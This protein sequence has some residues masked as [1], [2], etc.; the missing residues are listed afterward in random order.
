[1]GILDDL[2]DNAP[3]AGEPSALDRA[4]TQAPVA[5]QTIGDYARKL[6]RG[7]T[8]AFQ[9]A[10]AQIAS[11]LGAPRTAVEESQR[12]E[13]TITERLSPAGRF[14][15][16]APL[17][18]EEGGLGPAPVQTVLSAAVESAPS[19]VQAFVAGKPIFDVLG[20]ARVAERVAGAAQRV[21][22]G[23]RTAGVVG[24]AAEAVPFAAVEGV[25]AGVM[26][27]ADMGKR[28]RD[29]S[30][31]KLRASPA[32]DEAY[33]ATDP[34]ASPE[35]RLA[36][37]REAIAQR[38]ERQ[39]LAMT[40]ASTGTIGM[41]TGA[42]VI[43]QF[44]RRLAGRQGAEAA[45]DT[46][47]KATIK[48]A[49]AEAAQETPQSGA[50]QLIANLITRGLIDPNQPL[51][52][53]VLNAAITGGAAGGLLGGLGG[54][55]G[56][57]A[58]RAP[59]REREPTLDEIIDSAPPAG[60]TQGPIPGTTSAF[61]ET[62]TPP[63]D[64]AAGP[65][66]AGVAAGQESGAIATNA[67]GGPLD[68][69]P[70]PG[71]DEAVLAQR[72]AQQ[73][74]QA[75]AQQAQREEKA[76]DDESE[77]LSK[78][79]ERITGALNRA[80]TGLEQERESGNP[81][82]IEYRQALVDLQRDRLAS[83]NERLNRLSR[84]ASGTETLDDA[85][86]G[87]RPGAARPGT[88]MAAAVLGGQSD[89]A[90][91]S[92]AP[93][94]PAPAGSGGAGVPAPESSSGARDGTGDRTHQPDDAGRAGAVG[95]LFVSFGGKLYPVD[96]LEDAAAKWSQFR[97]TS[98]A[99]VSKI[100]NGVSVVDAAG[101][102]VGRVSYNG[103]IW[104]EGAGLAT[105]AV[106]PADGGGARP[107]VLQNRDRSSAA[108]VAQMA[109]IAGNP[110]PKRLS[111]SR[112]FGTGAPVVFANADAAA[113][114]ET[115]LGAADE[116]VDAS[117]RT[118]PVQY[119][120]VEAAEVVASNRADGAPNDLYA[121]AETPGLIRAV[122][123]NGRMAGLQEAF[124]RGTAAGYV[125]GI[126]ADAR[127][128]GVDPDVIRGMQNPVLVR[129]MR[130]ADVTPD[131]GDRSNVSGI[132][133]LNPVEQARTDMAR[134][135]LDGLEFGEDGAPTVESVRRFVQAMPAP[136]QSSLMMAGGAPGK[137]AVDRLMAATFA[138]AYGATDLIELYA[139]ATDPEARNVISALA[140]AAGPMARL[141]GAGDLDIRPAV[142]EAVRAA[143]NASRRGVSLA[144][145]SQ[146]RDFDVT[147]EAWRVV[148]HF[149]ANA[150]SAKRMAEG[151]RN[152]ADAAYAESQKG[153]V[154]MF[155]AVPKRTGG[156]VINEVFDGQQREGDAGADAN[157]GRAGLDEEGA[158]GPGGRQDERTPANDPGQPQDADRPADG[159]AGDFDLVAPTRE[160]ILRQQEAAE[161]AAQG[162]QTEDEARAR[163]DAEREAADQVGFLQPP[164]SGAEQR[165]TSG[166]M[167]GGPT[168]DDVLA[169]RERERR[170]APEAGGMFAAPVDEAAAQ[171]E[172]SAKR[173]RPKGHIEFASPVV[174]P[175][176]AKLTD[177][178]W[179]W[180]YEESVDERG[181]ER[182]RRISDWDKAEE[183]QQTGR[184]IVHQF[185][186]EMPDGTGQVVSA[187]TALQLLGFT[188]IQG[189]SQFK[190]VESAAKTLARTQMVLT[191]A[192]QESAR[193]K[194]DW[195][196][197]QKM[198]PP[199]PESD[200]QRP[201]PGGRGLWWSMGDASIRQITDGPL[202]QST[203]EGLVSQWRDNRM[204]EKGWK[205]SDGQRLA[206]TVS[207]LKK[208]IKVAEKRIQAI[209][210]AASTE[211]DIPAFETY[212]DA[213]DWVDKQAE[214]F[215]S[216]KQ[217]E[218]TNLYRAAYPQIKA[219]Y[220]RT[221]ARSAAAQMQTMTDA[222]IKVGDLVQFTVPGFM[223]AAGRTY[224][225]T[226][227][228][229]GGHPV[230]KID[231]R[232]EFASRGGRT[233][234]RT[235]VAWDSR[236]TKAAAQAERSD[237]RV[238]RDS[239]LA[240]GT[241]IY[242][243]QG[244]P[245]RVHYQRNDLVVAHPIIDG[246]PR[247]SAD[248]SVRFWVNPDRPA[249]GENDRTDPIYTA[250]QGTLVARANAA[251]KGKKDAAAIARDI[252]KERPFDDAMQVRAAAR[253][254]IREQLGQKALDDMS[255]GSMM[256]SDELTQAVHDG[257]Y[258]GIAAIGRSMP[259]P[260]T[261]S[262]I[263][264]ELSDRAFYG[265]SHSPERR[266]QSARREYVIRMV[267][268]WTEAKQ[269][270][271]DDPQALARITDEFEKLR[272]GYL[273]RYLAYLGAHSNVQSSMIAGP[274]RFPVERNRKRSEAADKRAAD[275]TEFLRKGIERLKKSARAP[276]DQSPASEVERIRA[277]LAERERAQKQMKAVNAALRKGD[278]A[279]LRDLGLTDERIAQLKKPDFAGRTGFPSY[280]LTNN[281]AE[282]R[283]LRQ[284]LEQAEQRAGAAAEGPT[285]RIVGGV[286]IEE[287]AQANRIRLYFDGKPDEATRT[288][289]KASGF[290][291]A[292]SVGAWQRQLT[293]SARAAAKRVLGGDAVQEPPG[294]RYS[295]HEPQ[296]P[297]QQ[298]EL[299]LAEGGG[300]SSGRPGLP[301]PDNRARRSAVQR[302]E[303]TPEV[304][305]ETTPDPAGVY[306]ARTELV[307][308][309]HRTIH[310]DRVTNPQ[311]AAVALAS[312]ADY[313]V[314][315]FHG[316]VTDKAGKPL[317]LVGMFRG[318][319]AETRVYAETIYAEAF[320]VKGAANIWFTH[321]HPS[322]KAEF[323]A[324][325]RTMFTVLRNALQGTGIKP[326]GFFAQTHS[327][328]TNSPGAWVF[329][330]NGHDT[331]HGQA[332]PADIKA[333]SQAAVPVVERVIVEQEPRAAITNPAVAKDAAR[334]M[335][336]TLGT[337]APF[338]MLMSAQNEPIGAYP[339]K[340]GELAILR[341]G[342][343]AA[344]LFRA[345]STA[346]ARASILVDAQHAL[347]DAELDNV[348]GALSV[349]TGV[350]PLDALIGKNL[351][352]RMETGGWSPPLGSF[353]S[354]REK[355][356][357]GMNAKQVESVANR[358]RA[359]WA[360]GPEVVVLGSFSDA[361]AAVREAEARSKGATG[362]PEGFFHD[363]KVYLVAD[364]LATPADVAR[365]LFHEALGH[366]GLRGL[367]GNA[368]NGVLDKVIE[369]RRAEVIA[370]M[371]EYGLPNTL[372]GRRTAAEEVLAGLAQTQPKLNLVRAAIAAI[373]SWLR[374]VLPNLRV[375][376]DELVRD[377]IVPARE[378]VESGAAAN[379]EGSAASRAPG[380][381]WTSA[382]EQSIAA[383][384]ARAQPARQWLAQINA[385]TTKGVKADEIEWS[386]IREWLELQD[387]RVTKEA[388]L[389]YLSENGVRVE[390][391]LLG[392]PETSDALLEREARRLMREDGIENPTDEQVAEFIEEHGYD[393]DN[394]RDWQ[395]LG[396]TKFGNYRVPGSAENYREL[397]LTLPPA[398]EPRFQ[399]VVK[400][401]GDLSFRFNGADYATE[402]EARAAER[403]ARASE[404]RTPHWNQPNVLAHI[405]FDER[406]DADGKRVLFVNE[407]QSDWG[408][409]GRKH[410]F[411]TADRLID[412]HDYDWW[413][414]EADRLMSAKPFDRDAAMRAAENRDALAGKPDEVARGPFV[415]KTDAWVAL[416]L[417]RVIRYAVDNG[418]DRVALVNGEQ[419]ADM[420]N[421]AS[422]ID[423]LGWRANGDGTVRITGGYSRDG[424]VSNRTFGD[425]PVEKL[426]EVV[427]KDLAEKIRTAI[428]G[429]AEANKGDVALLAR[430]GIKHRP[431]VA[432][433]AFETPEG[434]LT[435][436]EFADN[437][438]KAGPDVVAAAKRIEAASE[439]NGGTFSGLD[440]RVGGEGMEKFYP[441]S[442]L[443]PVGTDKNGKPI[444]PIVQLVA[445]KVLKQIGGPAL[446]TV[447]MPV[448]GG[449]GRTMEVDRGPSFGGRQTIRIADELPMAQPGFDI[450]P[451]MREQ[452]RAGVPMFSRAGSMGQRA[453]DVL[454]SVTVGDVV[455]R[456]GNR[457]TDL[458][459]IGLQALG[460]RQLT[461]VYRGLL[462][463]LD[464]YG[465][466][467]QQ[468]DAEKNETAA[469][470]DDLARR[471]GRLTDERAVADVMHDATLAGW[472]PDTSNMP[473]DLLTPE[474]RNLADRFNALT[475]QAKEVYREARDLYARHYAAVKAAVRARIERAIPDHARRAE[476]L[477]RM[478]A[479]MFG[480]L[481]GV[482]FPLARFGEYVVV[483]KNE[484]GQ[485]E[486]VSRAET[487]TEAEA[488]R[489]QLLRRFPASRGFTVGKILKSREFN[490]V[491]DGVGRGFLK[492]LY[493]LLD[494]EGVG[495]QLQDSINQLYLSSLPDLS[496]AK[497]GLHRKG[498]P[499]FSQDA[500]RAFA[501][502]VFHGARY[503][504]KL[505]H[506]DRLADQLMAMQEHVDERQTD[507]SYDSIAG[508]QVVDE[509]VKRHESYMNPNT[510][511]TATTAT[512]LGFVFY[513]GLSPASAAVN[514]SQTPLVAYPLMG[515]KWGFK[516]AGALLLAASRE[517]A[518][519]G[520][521]LSKTLKDDELAAFH[522]AAADGTIDVTQAHDL[523]GIAQGEDAKVVW[524]LRPVMRAASFLFHHAERF[525]R[526]A[527]FLASYR[528]AKQASPGI[529]K[530]EAYRQ[531]K[532][533]TYDAHFDYSS[534]SRPRI[535][536]GNVARVVLLF[537]QFA[538]NMIWTL[539]RTGYMAAK[540]DKQALRAFSALVTS[541]ALAAGVLGLPLVGVLLEAAS[542]LGSSDDEPWDA[543]GALRNYMAEAIGKTP[544]AV[545]AHGLSRLTPWDISGRVGL[546][547]LIF[548]DV[549]EGL[550]GESWAHAAAASA[551]GPVLNMALIGPA[552]GL[553]L[554]ADGHWMRGLEAM[555]PAV[556]R[557]GLKSVRYATEGA[558]TRDGKTI[559][560][561][562]GVAEWLGQAAGFSPSRVRDAG[563]ARE[564]VFGLD[565]RINA[566]R[567]SLIRDYG[568]AVMAKDHGAMGRQRE[569]VLRFNAANPDRPITG[570]TIVQS[571]RMRTMRA[572]EAEKGIYLP[573][574]RRGLVEQ[575][576]FADVE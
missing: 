251:L 527:T 557:S 143:V 353:F 57:L 206:D 130:S 8:S 519:A 1:M 485:A 565:R 320:R 403:A 262:Q 359:T 90:R 201:T 453:T 315:H 447:Q 234:S 531:A 87:Q 568:D 158:G 462:P 442:D 553:S 456:F 136:E 365:V 392:V 303:A 370:K 474:M 260:V 380:T 126:A 151:L 422:Q 168:A 322:G 430:H 204:V 573:R 292:P 277:N 94:L 398:G 278:D 576:R 255:P 29:L 386:G 333:S 171:A 253:E 79:A 352:S 530:D 440:L 160:D 295:V 426:P 2:V 229:R 123:G 222:G 93:A 28:V 458:R 148:E 175:S 16:S 443:G 78:A 441:R 450:T 55:A 95:G 564:I 479:E 406:T 397:L 281:N 74:E 507:E 177:Y 256:T 566:R 196:A 372:D 459:G 125:E 416:A 60:E 444:Y 86:L 258:E 340:P 465:D 284:R 181:E 445:Q 505:R 144:K 276:A 61:D 165:D 50:E 383:I 128:H 423:S 511:W 105:A 551:A 263:G 482:Y 17:V 314:E 106:P 149:V 350:R 297:T 254:A 38:A 112:E 470:A 540:G 360:N 59:E 195:D 209:T 145:F 20:R 327:R 235:Q 240:D 270:A 293:D 69:A 525:N 379:V 325:D 473:A 25:Q 34:A 119:A 162:E 391:V 131:I 492:E 344:N 364:A 117:G 498:T 385:L 218:A 238:T 319:F 545:V 351:A 535:M 294:A 569:A 337:D 247:V 275:A 56:R 296:R 521:D 197:V 393:I 369:V 431:D 404:F 307:A 137:Q 67:I 30:D 522:R 520:N 506:A 561:D 504:A 215:A 487:L 467:V 273:S 84:K 493:G 207:D 461:E 395:R 242:D 326:R 436:D 356:V 318:S 211:H 425:Y 100:G 223:L 312:V 98:G 193:W 448:P 435:A 298:I 341:K 76:A 518:A 549:R 552:K 407:L 402:Q 349:A 464:T 346:N 239:D 261:E 432:D 509:M 24:R 246:K 291:W 147:P 14:V 217:F 469:E 427:G 190:S 122:A 26:A 562:V 121:D 347:T 390:E 199:Q 169:Q 446:T 140:R 64:P 560:E 36:A 39:A 542:W 179:Q 532:K 138:K 120:V 224:T 495:E 567:A 437:G 523:A 266:G 35:S 3:P 6:Q 271:S 300:A 515:A 13:Q 257:Q 305:L 536:Q 62:L 99:G 490:A 141:E 113:I 220:D 176:G 387:G 357:S 287:D 547:K 5:R 338:V 368:L 264:T 316:L 374:R 194:A 451:A 249:S 384:N 572:A 212:D 226:V 203:R 484:A 45:A 265:T 483:V 54:G 27:A 129:V 155:G 471:W 214:P 478:E 178:Q 439:K 502:N 19:L 308:E 18:S 4:V 544:G 124:N 111:Y 499:G 512:S 10:P 433:Y 323:S 205:P 75:R 7:A 104:R 48:G 306:L 219:L 228:D 396:A 81:E 313:A 501:Q 559:V 555:L 503:L 409:R 267:E 413:S 180:Q 375:T 63:V 187:E 331:I 472:D 66:S 415:E 417:K 421:L 244:K 9:T 230:V 221:Q 110:D 167:F 480:S 345:V 428:A 539:A 191:G 328:G 72:Q 362:R 405:R 21:G 103:R 457:L 274:A 41:A 47:L 189:K 377:Y 452:V 250:P 434:L 109:S 310:A 381:F 348:A 97:D 135:N 546:D 185:G 70:E 339:L 570:A 243:G 455:H 399:F 543:E 51:T 115:Q 304:R 517:T 420:F 268:A 400:E 548:P 237:A 516:R 139:Q 198:T 429:G 107:V 301:G 245:Y 529:S 96:S 514:L 92:D 324:S 114:P 279:A 101:N 37:A 248:T 118:V 159:Q 537:K 526:Q 282:I 88:D 389:D 342:E 132:S 541:H 154:D 378:W 71:P 336:T 476:M 58:Q 468:M 252:A 412:G 134:V 554:I 289:L 82:A 481:Q 477:E 227:I 133:Q 49:G 166:D 309:R 89:D 157:A 411:K 170:N 424:A 302:V 68:P 83:I 367:Y 500:R 150:R 174:G 488:V 53:G 524:R 371:R 382:L 510:H 33:A 513:L 102:E 534:S 574:K 31:E 466:I 12:A 394:V 334:A 156:Q 202:T 153:D 376:D 164:P 335:Q 408:Q 563:K 163:L 486:A 184:M 73:Q 571:V 108:S 188:D 46:L 216:R 388:V 192:E 558:Q 463:Q 496:W 269:A 280:E 161:R 200:S 438:V 236:W 233:E 354:R 142:M 146:Q 272:D 152:L 317:A 11:M 42:G 419:A 332:L 186:V 410:G 311:E 182:I 355:P 533:M 401:G 508:Q 475:P 85:D 210:K 414:R 330:D 460:R 575:G 299:P 329:T 290:K 44:A 22:V 497:H 491:R 285:E 127:L 283:R 173:T 363:G 288:A 373:R 361:P 538:Q 80:L 231:G 15:D 449:T 213:L 52:D 259:V 208:R 321:N 528:L 550:E 358:V 494:Q 77:R 172:K 241:T 32:F 489:A 40:G 91:R 418:F 43:G 286:R 232:M 116:V 454:R 366:Y 343:R 23:A 225:G 556:L 65:L 183:N